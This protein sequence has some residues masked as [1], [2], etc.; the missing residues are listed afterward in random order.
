MCVCMSVIDSNRPTDLLQTSFI[1]NEI[2]ENGFSHMFFNVKNI[3][4]RLGQFLP[5]RNYFT[6]LNEILNIYIFLFR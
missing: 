1:K 6:D 4:D 2:F 5:L 3:R